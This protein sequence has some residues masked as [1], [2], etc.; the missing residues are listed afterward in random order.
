MR[1]KERDEMNC[2]YCKKDV[3]EAESIKEKVKQGKGKNA[4]ERIRH[5]H[6]TCWKKKNPKKR[7]TSIVGGFR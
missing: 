3:E 7:I 6:S 4:V 5:Y 1:F 2:N